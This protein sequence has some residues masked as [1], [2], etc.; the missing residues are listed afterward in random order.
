M[1]LRGKIPEQ[2][3]H[4]LSALLNHLQLEVV[5]LLQLDVVALCLGHI[6]AVL[7]PGPGSQGCE[8]IRP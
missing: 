7:Q 1:H 4:L 5:A 6:V 8:R 3:L 2:A